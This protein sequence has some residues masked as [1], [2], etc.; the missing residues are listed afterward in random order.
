M[1]LLSVK[2]G[3]GFSLVELTVAIAIFSTGLGSFSLLLMMAIQGT[4]ES[5]LATIAL[6]QSRSLAE[7]IR[8]SPGAV[9][10]YQA[11]GVSAPCFDGN[12]CAPGKMAGA[13]LYGWSQQLARQL[14]GG[15]GLACRDSSPNDGDHLDGA[16]D[17]A[18]NLVVKVF[19]DEPGEDGNERVRRVVNRLPLL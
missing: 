8:M 18:G 7:S 16:C 17:D 3:L 11:G 19:W 12:I 5:R 9:A 2:R 15:S 14:P 6:A 10:D 13:T 4:A 1:R